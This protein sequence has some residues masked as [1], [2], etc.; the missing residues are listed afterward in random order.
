[1]A[2]NMSA[3]QDASNTEED[4]RKTEIEANKTAAEKQAKTQ[5]FKLDKTVEFRENAAKA[6]KKFGDW[7]FGGGLAGL[8]MG[9]LFGA[10]PLVMGALMAGG[11]YLGGKHGQKLATDQLGGRWFKGNQE[12]AKQSMDKSITI[13]TIMSG[14]MGGLAGG[15]IK[16]AGEVGKIGKWGNIKAGIKGIAGDLTTIGGGK[17]I[18]DT[19][20]YKKDDDPYGMQGLSS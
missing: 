3:Y 4:I 9:L 15:G 13:D 17:T 1:M 19:M 11:T 5:E 7:K 20:G 8:G 12:F 18:L 16:E 6:S 10:N 2:F 14:I